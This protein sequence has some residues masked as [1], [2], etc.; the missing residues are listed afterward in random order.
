MAHRPKHLARATH[1]TL[2]TG[3]AA[4]VMIKYQPQ[5]STVG[6]GG[7]PAPPAQHGS[8]HECALWRARSVI[9]DVWRLA[10]GQHPAVTVHEQTVCLQPSLQRPSRLPPDRLLARIWVCCCCFCC[11]YGTPEASHGCSPRRPHTAACFREE[12][13]LEQGGERAALR[14]GRLWEILDRVHHVGVVAAAHLD[15]GV[16]PGR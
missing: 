4:L 13:P 9:R 3:F 6:S 16:D 15:V 2:S 7:I 10:Q 12:G 14:Y 1:K 8:F 5:D 11:Y